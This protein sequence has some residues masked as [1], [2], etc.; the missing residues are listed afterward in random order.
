MRLKHIE[1]FTWLRHRDR[2]IPDSDSHKFKRL[3]KEASCMPRFSKHVQVD[4]NPKGKPRGHR[5][6]HISHPAVVH[7]AIR[8]AGRSCQGEGCQESAARP[9]AVTSP[10]IYINIESKCYRGESPV[11]RM[12]SHTTK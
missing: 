1:T 2:G 6:D 8:E 5:R 12:T 11:I 4:D 3:I 7:L 9:A 10:Y